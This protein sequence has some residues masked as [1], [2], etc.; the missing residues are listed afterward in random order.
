MVAGKE[1]SESIVDSPLNP[2]RLKKKKKPVDDSEIE[3]TVILSFILF[4]GFIAVYNDCF[5]I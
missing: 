5:K 2:L 4:A 1:V 3:I